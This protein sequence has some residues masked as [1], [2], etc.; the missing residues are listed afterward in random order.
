MYVSNR[1]VCIIDTGYDMTHPD[2]SSEPNVVTGYTGSLSAGD[3]SFDGN[4][5]GT[6]VAGTIA[7]L[8][9]NG[10]GVTGV[11]RN[12]ELKLHIIKV[13]DNTGDWAWGSTLIAAVEKC[14]DAGANVVNMSLGGGGFS[15]AENDAFKRVFQE[16][17][18]LLVAAAGNAG[19]TAYSYPASY[20][21][22]MS[23]GA[24][25]S[26]NDIA[27]F[28]Q[29]NDQVDISAPGVRIFS[30]ISTNVATSGYSTLSG[31]SMATPHVTGVAALIWSTHPAKS[32]AE[33]RSALEDSAQDL[34]P[35][36]R[37]NYYGHGLV[38]A[39]LAATYLNSGFSS[40]PTTSTTITCEDNPKDWYDSDGSRF[41]CEWYSRNFNCERYGGSYK[42]FGKT[43]NE[44]CCSCGGGVE[45][46]STSSNDA[47]RQGS[48]KKPPSTSTFNRNPSKMSS[49]KSPI[50]ESNFKPNS[51]RKPSCR[52]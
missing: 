37:D 25:D 50:F 42:N 41:D 30:T 15:Q 43:A 1:K 24:T 6:H 19:N 2:L 52:K 18:V 32:A 14:V 4:G 45:N 13:F 9:G 10:Q 7:A 8:G 40:S 46:A 21:Y 47:N 23:V 44:A 17:N 31:T 27:W 16:K 34:G 33:I 22:V 51:T 3:W 28:S 38:R 48:S 5:H 35:Q 11:N 29:T 39:D 26:N 36:G 12:G 20:N 49:T